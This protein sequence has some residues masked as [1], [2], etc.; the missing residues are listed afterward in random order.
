MLTDDLAASIAEV[1]GS[2]S[3]LPGAPVPGRVLLVDADAL[4]YACAGNDDTTP[5]EARHKLRERVESA[6]RAA[7]APNVSFL[8]TADASHKGHRF[9]IARA[10]PYQGGRDHGHRPKNRDHLRTTMQAPGFT[11]PGGHTYVT[12]VEHAEAD[13]LFGANATSL[14]AEN[15]VHYTCDKDMRMVPGWHLHWTEHRMLWVPPGAFET[16]DPDGTV[17]GE[18]WFWLQMLQGDSADNIPGL[19][20]LVDAKGKQKKIGPVTAASLLEGVRCGQDAFTS[21]RLLYREHYGEG[22]DVQMAEQGVLL[23]MRRDPESQWWDVFRDG[24]P[25]AGLLS[26]VLPLLDRVAAVQT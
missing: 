9:A 26:G 18:K 25:L 7:C 19:P 6:L 23:W 22:G 5:A 10:K 3:M 15:C 4:A 24:N 2:V 21:V 17:Y 13:D 20:W 11:I 12:A 8:L 1:E 14:G 16:L